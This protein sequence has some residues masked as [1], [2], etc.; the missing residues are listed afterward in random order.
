MELGLHWIRRR[1]RSLA[2][3]VLAL[4]CL[5][6]LQAAAVPCVMAQG[7]GAMSSPSAGGLTGEAMHHGQPARTDGDPA[8]HCHYCP[9]PGD[10]GS[11]HDSPA[12]CAY[13]H[14]PQVDARHAVGAF[15]PVLAT[16]TWQA[17]VAA[18][19]LSDP[20]ELQSHRPRSRV[21]ITVS[22]CRF[23]E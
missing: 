5:A 1:Q 21:P 8:D 20:P 3:G 7:H 14:G 15:V 6:W 16:F 11:A 4:F 13:P 9:P 19:G 18:V 12:T 23:I 2:K 10:S 22:L 17:N